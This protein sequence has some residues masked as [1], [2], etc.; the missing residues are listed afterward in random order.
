MPELKTAMDVFKLLE[1]SNCRECN[2]ATCLAFAGAVFQGRH[3][4]R[5]ERQPHCLVEEFNRFIRRKAQVGGTQFS[6]LAPGAQ[7]GQG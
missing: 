7:A 2:E 1:K 4:F 3:L 5:Q 6:Q